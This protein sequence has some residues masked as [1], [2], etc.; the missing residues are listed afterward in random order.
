[1]ITNNIVYLQ[2]FTDVG[3]QDE[4]HVMFV[5]M[6]SWEKESGPLELLSFFEASYACLSGKKKLNIC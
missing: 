2:S 6:I 1:M 3:A 5:L 4:L